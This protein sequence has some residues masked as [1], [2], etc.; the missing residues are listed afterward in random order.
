V[1]KNVT[2]EVGPPE[3]KETVQVEVQKDL[4]RIRSPQHFAGT[5]RKR[6]ANP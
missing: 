4:I 3:P 6:A 5:W 2:I 1:G